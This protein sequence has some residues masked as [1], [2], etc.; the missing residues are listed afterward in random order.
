MTKADAIK[1][2]LKLVASTCT[3]TLNAADDEIEEAVP[4]IVAG[5]KQAAA[6]IKNISK[7]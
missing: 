3:D 1:M 5:L 2:I 6:S 4:D 7:I